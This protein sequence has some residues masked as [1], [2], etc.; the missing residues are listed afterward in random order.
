ML[1]G[2][3]LGFGAVFAREF[4]DP[5]IQDDDEAATELGLPVLIS[6]PNVASPK[7]TLV[8]SAKTHKATLNLVAPLDTDGQKPGR[9]FHLHESIRVL[10]L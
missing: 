3:L 1:A 10:D 4:L 8:T 5:T 2:V 6:I 7:A 9:G